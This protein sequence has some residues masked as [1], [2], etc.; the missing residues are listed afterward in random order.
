MATLK[1]KPYAEELITPAI[2]KGYLISVESYGDNILEDLGKDE[3]SQDIDEVLEA[4]KAVDECCIYLWK[5]KEDYKERDCEGWLYWIAYNEG[6]ER[7]SDYSINL[8]ESIN[9]DK[10]MKK[11][12]DKYDYLL[13]NI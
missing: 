7:L 11:W 10:I 2:K 1:I 3:L 6:F 8:E 5:S 13:S 12:I 4:I 9:L